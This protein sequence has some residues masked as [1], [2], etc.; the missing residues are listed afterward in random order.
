LAN[1]ATAQKRKDCQAADK[2]QARKERSERLFSQK[3]ERKVP[4]ARVNT[5]Q[6]AIN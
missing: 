5:A 1:Q 3:I 4:I 6:E 2:K